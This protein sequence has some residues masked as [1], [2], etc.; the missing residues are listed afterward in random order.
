[1]NEEKKWVENEYHIT[2]SFIEVTDNNSIRQQISTF[3][4][5]YHNQNSRVS[6]TRLS[7]EV[8]PESID[9]SYTN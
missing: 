9:M 3:Y 1:M 7:R 5:P 8:R 6:K 4:D 2:F